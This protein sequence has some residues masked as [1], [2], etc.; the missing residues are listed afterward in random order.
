[1]SDITYQY[2]KRYNSGRYKFSQRSNFVKIIP[3]HNSIAG[4]K[5]SVCVLVCVRARGCVLTNHNRCHTHSKTC[6][7]ACTGLP[8]N[9]D[10]EQKKPG[11]PDLI[12]CVYRSGQLIVTAS[13]L[14]VIFISTCRNYVKYIFI[15]IRHKL[16]ASKRSRK[17]NNLSKYKKGTTTKSTISKQRDY[18][19]AFING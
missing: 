1:M 17:D 5:L 18:T 9:S 12:F 3:E 11:Q 15:F 13:G 7:H 4:H 14:L 19:L 16:V 10:Y 6:N 2:Q 8:V